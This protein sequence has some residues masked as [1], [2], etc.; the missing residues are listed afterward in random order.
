MKAPLPQGRNRLTGAGLPAAESPPKGGVYPRRRLGTG[1]APV[2]N[3]RL[4]LRPVRFNSPG[5]VS[6]LEAVL[7]EQ[8][9]GI[10]GCLAEAAV[11]PDFAVAG[12]FSEPGGYRRRSAQ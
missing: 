9:D 12:Q 1:P 7:P 5:E 8:A 3:G 10:A 6:D 11:D 2:S 4:A